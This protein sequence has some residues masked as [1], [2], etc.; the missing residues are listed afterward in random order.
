MKRIRTIGNLI[1]LALLGGYTGFLFAKWSS[2]P[3]QIPTHFNAAGAAD[4]YGSKGTLI[5]LSVLML[6]MFALL[7]GIECFPQAWN[8][9][10]KV[11]EEN[12]ERLYLIT[13]TMLAIV[14]VLLVGMFCTIGV[15]MVLGGLSGWAIGIP[16]ALL[17]LTIA[18]GIAACTRER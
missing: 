5:M 4:S 7:A 17:F 14:K 11:T 16:V 13:G 8:M 18:V 10:V 9:P 1:C 2:L 3:E 15:G 12:K 6:L